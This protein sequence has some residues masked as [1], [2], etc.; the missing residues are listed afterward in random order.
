VDVEEC[1]YVIVLTGV[2]VH[3]KLLY[4]LCQCYSIWKKIYCKFVKKHS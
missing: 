3:T 2:N 1:V 4:K